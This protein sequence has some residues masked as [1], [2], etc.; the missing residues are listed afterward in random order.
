ML[1]GIGFTAEHDLHHHVKRALVLDGLLG[2]S[3]ELTRKAGAGLRARGS[4]PRL[5]QLTDPGGDRAIVEH[6]TPHVHVRAHRDD[7]A[8]AQ[9]RGRPRT[10]WAMML[11]WISE[12]P[13]AMVPP[14]LRA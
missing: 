12:V 1:G 4:A 13:P 5:A 7:R 14:K 6:D 9:P 10:R 2:S 3:R 8:P 11:R